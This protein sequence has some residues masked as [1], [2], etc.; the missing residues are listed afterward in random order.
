MLKGEIG[1]FSVAEILQM[2]AMQEKTGILHLRSRGRSASIFFEG[3][4]VISTRD[5]RQSSRDAFLTYL[6]EKGA[7]DLETINR[8]TELKQNQGGDLIE[9][10]LKNNI[11]EKSRLAQLLSDYAVDTLESLVKWETG[12]FEFISTTDSLPEKSIVKPM[13]LEPILMEALRRK[14]EVEQIRRF[15]PSFD[16]KI[17]VAVPDVEELRLEDVDRQI[18]QLINGERSID[19][20]VELS[21]FEEV[22]ALDSLERLFALGIVAIVEREP[23]PLREVSFAQVRIWLISIAAIAIALALRFGLM[24][25]GSEVSMSNLTE[26]VATFVEARRL[27]SVEFALE[28]YRLTTGTYPDNLEDLIDAYLVKPDEIRNIKG[29]IFTYRLT[30]E[31]SYV[32]LR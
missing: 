6:G 8:V 27:A 19:E 4:K 12:T 14:D 31:D 5:R 26:S 15:L 7:I 29:E 23:K 25:G 13:R 9:V 11:L 30:S 3:G 2:I 21:G 20:V 24:S 1:P 32:L 22:E 17:R 18:L 16:T 28:V 10:I